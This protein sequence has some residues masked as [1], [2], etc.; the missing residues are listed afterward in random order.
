MNISGLM[1]ELGIHH[2][3]QEWR[4]FTDSSITSLK[5]V[6]LYNGNKLSPMPLAYVIEMREMYESLALL[7]DAIKYKDHEWQMC[8]HLNVVSL[9]TGFQGGFKNVPVFF[10]ASETAE[11]P[12]ITTKSRNSLLGIH[13]FLE[14]RI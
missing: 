14:K 3:P 7:L 13:N 6:L 10:C 5:A 1:T 11:T 9:L 12:K 8:C 2:N 4:L